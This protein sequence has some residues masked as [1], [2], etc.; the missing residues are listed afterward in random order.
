MTAKKKME[1]TFDRDDDG[2]KREGISDVEQW[3]E[4]E[5]DEK[6]DRDS[7]PIGAFAQVVILF[8]QVVF[9]S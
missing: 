7:C 8:Y 5:S 6:M 3:D 2:N 1:T 4:D 9:F